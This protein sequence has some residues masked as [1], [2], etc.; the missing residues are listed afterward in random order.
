MSY[1]AFVGWCDEAALPRLDILLL[2]RAADGDIE[3]LLNRCEK[4][5]LKRHE[6]I[7]E[8]ASDPVDAVLASVAIERLDQLLTAWYEQLRQTQEQVEGRRAE[9]EEAARAYKEA[10]VAWE[11]EVEESRSRLLELF[12]RMPAANYDVRLAGAVQPKRDDLLLGL[13]LKGDLPALRRVLGMT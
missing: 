4:A 3:S 11:A 6:L 7:A 2:V 5:A 1:A 12:E 13:L 9:A 8:A 10:L